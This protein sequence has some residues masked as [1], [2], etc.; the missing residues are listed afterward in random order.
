M[1]ALLVRTPDTKATDVLVIEDDRDTREFVTV[2]LSSRGFSTV[3]AENGQHAQVLLLNGLVPRLILLDLMMPVMDG[4]TF[5]SWQRTEPRCAAIPII[6][7]SA[8]A[9][10]SGPLSVQPVATMGKPVD[11]D[12]LGRMIA[13]LVPRGC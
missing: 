9:D 7:T 1:P 3:S 12:M 8:I 6:V 11:L 13:R 4:W 10:R 5:A 2:W